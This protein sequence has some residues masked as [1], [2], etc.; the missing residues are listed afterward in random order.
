MNS[1]AAVSIFT[2]RRRML[3]A[4]AACGMAAAPGLW[5]APFPELRWEALVPADWDPMK[6]FQDLQK[7]AAL[8]DSDPR[9]QRMY[10]RMRKVWDEAPTVASLEG[11]QARMPGFVVPLEGGSRGLR[12]FLLVPYF[13]ACIHTPPPPAN[14]IIHVRLD[15]PVKGFQSMSAVWVS[16]TLGL[17]RSDSELGV[18]G[19]SMK[20]RRVEKYQDR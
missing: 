20:A 18:S 17:E 10:D 14:Q 15:A 13:G 4:L 16:G 3:Q 6:S 12:E 8:P 19:Y 1:T 9:I 5:A 2:S 11:R 7:L